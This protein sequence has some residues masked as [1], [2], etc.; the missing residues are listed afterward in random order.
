MGIFGSK[1]CHLATPVPIG[2]LVQAANFDA[3][4]P[5]R[6]LVDELAQVVLDLRRYDGLHHRL[7]PVVFLKSNAR[8][9]FG[10]IF[11]QK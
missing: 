4:N 6:K 3:R 9:S 1:V 7:L 10:R 2:Y 5:A 11:R 8:I